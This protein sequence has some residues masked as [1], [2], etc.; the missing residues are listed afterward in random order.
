MMIKE[1]VLEIEDRPGEFSRIISHLYENDINVSAFSVESK[2]TK[3]QLRLI[4]SDP[5]STLSVLT[6]LNVQATPAE[7]L[8]V[9]VPDHPGGLNSVLKIL[10]SANLNIVHIYP[11][12]NTAE[13][14]LILTVDDPER[15]I[16]ALKDNWVKIYDERLYKL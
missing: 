7:A 11:C 2:R 16:K 14:I 5:E 15:A 4:T 13:A 1:I 9:Q 10:S 6:G 8:A 12:F 3:A